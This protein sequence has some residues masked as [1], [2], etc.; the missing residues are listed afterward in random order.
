LLDRQI[1]GLFAIQDVTDIAASQ[2]KCIRKICR[3][4]GQACDLNYVGSRVRCRDGM[5]GR[6]HNK[7]LAKALC[8]RRPAK[9]TLSF[10]VEA[11]S[12]IGLSPW[13]RTV[14]EKASGSFAN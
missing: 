8:S 10:A 9:S 1:A 4:A 3:I 7:L 12:A 2:V 6:E 11:I 13:S 14:R 5:A